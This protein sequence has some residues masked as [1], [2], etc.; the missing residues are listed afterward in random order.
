[1][2]VKLIITDKGA[3]VES[4]S[5]EPLGFKIAGRT[6]NQRNKLLIEKS[7]SLLRD[8]GY[9]QIVNQCSSQDIFK[10]A[11]DEIR[12][13]SGVDKFKIHIARDSARSA[14]AAAVKT[15]AVGRAS[16]PRA[17]TI[18]A[19]TRAAS[20]R[21]ATSSA[22][23]SS[24]APKP[25]S[26]AVAPAPKATVA[27]AATRAAVAKKPAMP[28][29][30]KTQIS[31]ASA[32]KSL[33]SSGA[34]SAVTTPKKTVTF[35]PSAST[36]RNRSDS[37]TLS[38]ASS[39]SLEGSDSGIPDFSS[40][41]SVDSTSDRDA[42]VSKYTGEA[43]RVAESVKKA[44]DGAETFFDAGSE[45]KTLEI[46]GSSITVKAAI[47]E[48]DGKKTWVEATPVMIDGE[49]KWISVAER[50]A[51]ALSGEGHITDLK[52][53][54]ATDDPEF[55]EILRD[56]FAAAG[57]EP[58]EI[59]K[60][61]AEYRGAPKVAVAKAERFSIK[62][63]DLVHDDEIAQAL[64]EAKAEAS[65]TFASRVIAGKRAARGRGGEGGAVLG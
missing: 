46:G 49:K 2:R 16:I 45:L 19:P 24:I 44:I 62:D 40:T 51:N 63:S 10:S 35:S 22:H 64:K 18:A 57:E 15:P 50:V 55:E 23:K 21:A 30:A 61:M 13:H 27:P 17:S 34:A 20:G 43:R 48:I 5:G 32:A 42:L 12:S 59:D 8:Y 54:V 65:E 28:A 60:K 3:H 38:Y 39:T 36:R 41:G 1:M 47:S 6:T 9:I 7:R 31:P 26:V 25:R 58:E 53:P 52:P 56:A 4:L 37:D 29:S 33:K 14:A 11:L